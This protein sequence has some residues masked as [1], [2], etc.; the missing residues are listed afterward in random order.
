MGTAVEGCY[1]LVSVY[2]N[3]ICCLQNIGTKNAG[4]VHNDDLGFSFAQ[5]IL[6]GR[7]IGAV[8]ADDLGGKWLSAFEA[9]EP[10]NPVNAPFAIVIQEGPNQNHEAYLRQNRAKPQLAEPVSQHGKAW[11]VGFNYSGKRA[12]L[13]NQPIVDDPSCWIVASKKDQ[14]CSLIGHF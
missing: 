8:N 9:V 1:T 7:A 6:A 14:I 3:R 2:E 13:L 12:E 5:E 11:H 10:A 4:A